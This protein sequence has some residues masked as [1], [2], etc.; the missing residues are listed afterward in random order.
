MGLFRHVI[1][2]NICNG[3]SISPMQLRGGSALKPGSAEGLKLPAIKTPDSPSRATC[4]LFYQF[5]KTDFVYEIPKN[6]KLNAK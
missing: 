6:W 1:E 5:A 3:I 4:G 2:L